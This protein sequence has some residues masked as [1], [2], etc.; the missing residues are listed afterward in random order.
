MGKP[1]VAES[2]A[3]RAGDPTR[4]SPAEGRALLREMLQRPGVAPRV[5]PMSFA[6]RRLWFLDQLVPGN[7][8]YNVDSAIRLRGPLQLPALVGSLREIVARHGAL[9]TT[10]A[11]VAG[12]PV[13]LV[14]PRLNLAVPVVDLLHLAEPER[15]R[16][17]LRLIREEGRRPFDLGRGPLI[18]CSLLLLAADD[19][20]LV[21]T[22]HHIVSDGWS[23]GV[24]LRELSAL[25]G[26]FRRDLPSP[27]PPLPLQYADFAARQAARLD[28]AALRDQL[29][30]WRRQLADLP[31][32]E[33]PT[34]RPR[35]AEP[36][37]T[38]GRVYFEIEETTAEALRALGRREGATLFMVLLAGFQVLMHRYCRQDDIAVGIPMAGRN[39]A[40]LEGLIGFFVNTLVIRGRLG[41]GLSFRAALARLRE[42]ALDAFAHQ[43]TPFERL[44]EELQPERDAS[45]NPLCQV[46]FAFQNA[47][48]SA[49]TLDGVAVSFPTV[50]ND[51]ARFDLVL[52]AWELP[53]LR[54]LSFRLEYARDLFDE[55]T[56]TAMGGHLATLLRTAA[57]A[58]DTPISR[59]PVLSEEERRRILLDWNATAVPFP[60]DRCVHQEVEARAAEAPDRPAVVDHEGT[61]TYRQLDE[62]ANQLAH[63]LAKRGAGPSRFVAVCLEPSRDWAVAL[64]AT[65]KVG[66]AYIAVDPAYPAARVA[67]MVRDC[68][69]V[70]VVT[71]RDLNGLLAGTAGPA[72]LRIDADAAAVVQCGRGSLAAPVRPGDPA[73]V[74]YTSGSTGEPNGVVLEHRGLMNLVSWHRRAYGVRPED[75]AS[76]IAGPGFDA[77]VWE[78]WPYLAAGASVHIAPARLRLDAPGLLDWLAGERIDLAF[79]STPLAEIAMA[80]KLPHDLRLRALLTGGDRLRLGQAAR[81]LPFRVVNHYGPS[82]CTVVATAADLG[83]LI[84]Q[85]PAGVSPPIGRPIDNT[86]IYI[87][88]ERGEPVP[89]RVP[90]EL[91]IAGAGVARGYLHRPDL[92]AERFVPSPFEKQ[93]MYRS[94]DRAR[95][96]HDGQ[97]EFLGRADAQV[98]IRGFRVEPGEVE[99][100]LLRHPEVMAAV[101]TPRTDI[102][103][104]V[105]LVAHVVPR[106]TADVLDEVAEAQVDHWR[107]LYDTTYGEGAAADPTFDI[108]GWRSSFTGL[109]ILAVEMRA[110][111][112]ATVRRLTSLR[113]A[114]VLEIGCGTG[115]LLH[116]LAP[117]C[118][119]YVGL[120]FSRVALER[121]G[122]SVAARGLRQVTL[123]EQRADALDD[124]PRE[125]FDLVV[126]NS[127]VQYFAGAEM[128]RR[129]LDGAVGRTA[130]GG[131]IFVGDVRS[132]PLQRAFQLSVA[133]H[134]A[135]ADLPIAAL[136]VQIDRAE[137]RE[138]ELLLAP[139]FFRDLAVRDP[140]LGGARILLRR[141]HHRNE[142]TRFRYDALLSVRTREDTGA[143]PATTGSQAE[144]PWLDWV[145]DG[146]DPSRLGALL[147]LHRPERLRVRSVPNARLDREVATAAILARNAP[148]RTVGELRRAL[149]AY[150]ATGPQSLDPE[151][152]HALAEREGCDVEA[153]WDECGPD[154]SFEL[155]LQ[156]AGPPKRPETKSETGELTSWAG[157]IA[158][159]TASA[160]P[161]LPDASRDLANNPIEA[162][163]GSLVVPQLR[164]FLRRQLPEAMVPSA[165]V[166][167]DELPLTPNGKINRAVLPDPPASRPDLEIE[168]SPPTTPAEAAIATLWGDL[169]GVEGVGVHDNFFDLGGHSLL[170]MQLVARLRDLFRVEIPV[171]MLFDHPTITGLA[172]AIRELGGRDAEA[173]AAVLP[174][175][176]EVA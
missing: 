122:R 59:L 150:P 53:G 50:S 149:A 159:R 126:L 121:L 17:A 130:P 25:Y 110:W 124:L 68:E 73:Y 115:L 47:P 38:G 80:C 176:G 48:T 56:V 140:R 90:G 112:D 132:L 118:E 75:R 63:L 114:R 46:L 21:V 117:A 164:Q 137:R 81:R 160:W 163:L 136:A 94:G 139:A 39:Q 86:Q 156:R 6:Q 175:P 44:V 15:T 30:Y 88:D 167:M 10:F 142:M 20:V 7:P 108:T 43:E 13:Q 147:R 96:R 60:S 144:S 87:L 40:D 33:L 4:R 105:R 152:A 51:T 127:V 45:R 41:G 67:R 32:L 100:L 134:R 72:V 95:W 74:V 71:R 157:G 162:K 27:L 65:L 64:L 83:S 26:A 113:P 169:L 98:S 18:R 103:A 19:H 116:R 35:P 97:I 165:F 70:A 92:T 120:D 14:H 151:D 133:L 54:T 172:F 161:A 131:T 76:Q 36:S 66:A 34:D 155:R 99:A 123:L 143:K 9:R 49:L 173:A 24:L 170:G 58:P 16:E 119:S 82:E 146:L 78:L 174:E 5:A 55:A 93:L 109:P 91:Y 168:W 28:E 106:R 141:G 11:L 77:A 135:P 52:D 22:L 154:G 129:V 102:Q 153:Y 3:H 107:A 61:I 1:T 29:G 69:P 2:G 42:T 138:E 31:Q 23:M 37:F 62:Q 85:G 128:L 89:A 158:L 166:L 125:H 57:N 12:Q 101:V 8:F 171:R 148:P 84:E 104:G 79:L 111:V 145:A